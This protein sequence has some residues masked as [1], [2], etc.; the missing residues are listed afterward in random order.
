MSSDDER[1]AHLKTDFHDTGFSPDGS[2]QFSVCIIETK[3]LH[4]NSFFLDL[5]N[6]ID[7]TLIENT[8]PLNKGVI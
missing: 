3:L 2:K 7:Y 6:I 5:H 1:I 4:R 8:R